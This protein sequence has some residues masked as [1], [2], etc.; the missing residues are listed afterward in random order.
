VK[1]MKGIIWAENETP[2]GLKIVME[3]PL[4]KEEA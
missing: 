1:G 4:A 3:F 2:H